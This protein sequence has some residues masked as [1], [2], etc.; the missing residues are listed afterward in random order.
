[1]E[2][3]LTSRQADQLITALVARLAD[4]GLL[5]AGSAFDAAAFHRLRARVREHFEVPQ[6]SVTPLMARALFAIGDAWRPRRLLVVGSY[7][8]NTLVWLAGRSLL[9]DDPGVLAVGSD[10]DP[11]ACAVARRNFAALGAHAG[12][13]ITETDGHTLLADPA[14]PAPVD[15]ACTAEAAWDLVLLDADSATRRKAVYDSLLDAALPA[16]RPGAVVLAH[17]TAL[18]LFAADLAGYLAR[19]RQP[20]LFS[21][22]AHLPLDACGLEIS[23]A[24]PG[25]LVAA[26]GKAP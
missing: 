5:P 14:L 20:E 15:P 10:L 9:A 1:M 17:D 12:V 26:E 25:P 11:D 19:T 4:G 18:P 8:G 7:C 13:W 22:T 2:R 3:R 23:I 24:A 21:S 16:L 6:T